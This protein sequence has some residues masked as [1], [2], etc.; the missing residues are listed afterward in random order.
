[1]LHAARGGAR[2]VLAVDSSEAAL[3]AAA[4]NFERNGLAEGAPARRVDSFDAARQLDRRGERFGVVII[5]PPALV[6]SRRHLAAGAKA[7]RDL[8]RAAMAM[9]EEDGVLISCSCSHHLDD[10][11]F[12]QVLQESARAAHRPFRILDWAG[13]SPDHPQLLAVPETHYLKCAVLQAVG[14]PRMR[15]SPGLRR[16][17]SGPRGPVPELPPPSLRPSSSR[18]RSSS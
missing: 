7:Y 9:L 12:R 11:L 17:S 6:K 8:N 10:V 3:A 18:P 13:E 16:D 5:D 1:G 14:G 2:S 4:P 15:G